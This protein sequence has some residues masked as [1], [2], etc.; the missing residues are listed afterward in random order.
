MAVLTPSGP[1]VIVTEHV[2]LAEIRAGTRPALSAMLRESQVA[3]VHCRTRSDRYA[4]RRIHR[5]AYLIAA[6]SGMR[7]PP[8]PISTPLQTDGQ[9]LYS[10]QP[11]G[12]EY[13]TL[14]RCLSEHGYRA[15]GVP[16]NGS[17]P[18]AGLLAMDP[19]GIAAT[20]TDDSDAVPV[21]CVSVPPEELEDTIRATLARHRA[22]GQPL[23][24]LTM[25]P[26]GDAWSTGRFALFARWASP[27]G[28]L[29]SPTTRRP[30]VIRVTDVGPT[31][32]NT[33]GIAAPLDIEGR[34]ASVTPIEP[35]L[36]VPRLTVLQG[37]AMRAELGRTAVFNALTAA[38][39]VVPVVALALWPFGEHRT[40]RL[41]IQAASYGLLLAPAV[42][43]VAPL[44]TDST[45]YVG[46]VLGSLGVAVAL[47]LG[48]AWLLPARWALVAALTATPATTI[49]DQLLGGQAAAF[50]YLGYS[51]QR[52][53]RLY[54][55]G[56][57]LAVLTI[58]TALLLVGA[59]TEAWPRGRR[60][61]WL[62]MLV[63]AAVIGAPQL[64]A[65]TGGLL[66]AVFA[67]ALGGGLAIRSVRARWAVFLLA[68]I[69]AGAAVIA[70]G[71]YD[72]Y[73]HADPTTHLGHATKQVLNGQCE[74]LRR[75]MDGKVR[76][77]KGR[78]S[79]PL[80]WGATGAT[81]LFVPFVAAD[82]PPPTPEAPPMR[83]VVAGAIAA[84]FA[85]LV[86]D[87][88][89]VMTAMGCLP[90]IAGAALIHRRV[91]R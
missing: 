26:R 50:S 6:A 65:N 7:L 35:E 77:V 38:A 43:A 14:A 55:M 37:R 67:A 32:L 79:T 66:T 19:H 30:G 45:D 75:T 84:L 27:P 46:V 28:L 39:I 41:V 63:P 8:G 74:W 10:R 16:S 22:S 71:L 68:P 33:L 59:L 57:S 25:P 3:L 58:V 49:G 11:L 87:S 64:G 52:D 42:L 13:G 21:L 2:P 80:W 61:W 73:C 17:A 83:Y 5:E 1:T 9:L 70:V 60:A 31:I 54:G 29:S 72:V 85:G 81:A 56:N 89:I 24:L 44:M 90:C 51:L 86:N 48:V 40:S 36:I 69:A 62:V 15:V 78:F 91:P 47:G 53:S 12:P 23:F 34:A 88:G 20:L 76:L 82:S 18:D 4:A